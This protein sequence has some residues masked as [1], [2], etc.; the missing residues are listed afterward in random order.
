VK[1]SCHQRVEDGCNFIS[2]S[3]GD[4]N[5]VVPELRFFLVREREIGSNEAFRQVDQLDAINGLIQ[6]EIEIVDPEFL[7]IA[8]HQV[9]WSIW[10]GVQ[11]VRKGLLVIPV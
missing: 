7:E 10:R 3:S 8:K 4:C 11:P 9:P 6:L 2:G 1:P 5:A